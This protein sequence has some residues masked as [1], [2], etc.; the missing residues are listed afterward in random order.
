MGQQNAHNLAITIASKIM[1][2]FIDS[3]S[4]HRTSARK[5]PAS[6]VLLYSKKVVLFACLFFCCCDKNSLTKATQGWKG[7]LCSRARGQQ[8]GRHLKQLAS[9]SQKAER[10]GCA[11]LLS[12]LS[13]FKQTRIQ[14]GSGAAH[15]GVGG[16]RGR[17][18][19]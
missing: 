8:G 13:P 9:W 12:S 11:L 15:W 17:P 19:N 5:W 18:R 10:D 14:P 1:F 6:H 16:G 7:L 2:L 4:E 3:Q